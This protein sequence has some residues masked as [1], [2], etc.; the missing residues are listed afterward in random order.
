MDPRGCAPGMGCCIEGTPVPEEVI[1]LCSSDRCFVS[2]GKFL[3]FEALTGELGV[4]D[5]VPRF[6]FFPLELSPD[7]SVASVWGV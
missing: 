6:L 5:S 2:R 7:L 1:G 4:S 3:F